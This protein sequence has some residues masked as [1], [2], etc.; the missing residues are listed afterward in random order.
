MKKALNIHQSKKY[1]LVKDSNPLLLYLL[2]QTTA[3]S[4]FFLQFNSQKKSFFRIC[5]KCQNKLY[6]WLYQ[7]L[8]FSCRTLLIGCFQWKKIQYVIQ[9]HFLIFYFV[10]NLWLKLASLLCVYVTFHNPRRH[11]IIEWFEISFII[12]IFHGPSFIC[13]WYLKIYHSL[14]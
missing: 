4:F 9:Y 11:T 3:L 6:S 2:S 13:H 7:S 14:V 1:P 5:D 8:R 10:F 12:T